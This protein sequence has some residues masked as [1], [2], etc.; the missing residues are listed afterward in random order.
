MRDL[1]QKT[2]NIYV[3]KIHNP[4]YHEEGAFICMDISG[5]GGIRP[6]CLGLN[7]CV[8]I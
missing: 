6:S 5:E 3:D 8:R 1:D 4:L 2:P 7:M